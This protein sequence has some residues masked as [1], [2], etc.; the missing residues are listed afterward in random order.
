MDLDERRRHLH[1][2]HAGRNRRADVQ[3]E[4]DPVDARHILAGQHRLFD[5]RTL[6]GREIDGG[7]A[8]ARRAGL[9]LLRSGAAF[10]RRRRAGLTLRLLVALHLRLRPGLTRPALRA[11]ALLG[12]ALRCLSGGLVL[13]TLVP[14]GLR[15]VRLAVGRLAG[16]LVRGL[17][18]L[19]IGRALRQAL[20]GRFL[21]LLA[22]R[23]AALLFRRSFALALGAALILFALSRFDLLALALHLGAVLP[24]LAT[25]LRVALR[26]ALFHA[27]AGSR[28]ALLCFVPRVLLCVRAGAR[29]LIARGR[30]LRRCNTDTGQQHRGS[31]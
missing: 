21:L 28:F 10:G 25:A 5:T 11:L 30:V 8:A 23:L 15:L 16:L 9:A 3:R 24:S 29:T 19:A 31:E 14:L 12:L 17:A 6:L 26:A 20:S 2:A 4:I 1:D 18:R 7:A 27:L 22:L 13:R